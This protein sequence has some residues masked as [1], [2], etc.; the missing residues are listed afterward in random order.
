MAKHHTYVEV[1]CPTCGS[2][3]TT[4]Q[5]C[6]VQA[7]KKGKSLE[8]RSC[9]MKGRELPKKKPEELIR[10]N[11]TYKSFCKAKRRCVMGARHHKSYEG[12][13]FRFESFEQFVECLGDRPPGMT[14]DRINPKGHYEPGNVRWATMRQQVE[15]RTALVCPYC[16]KVGISNMYRYHF[17]NCKHKG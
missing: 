4:R 11:P 2:S 17:E 8:C 14:L 13:E 3:R 5:D 7:L 9:A 15:N 6:L 10:N 12:V 16:G 1:V